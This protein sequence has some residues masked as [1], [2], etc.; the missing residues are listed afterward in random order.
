MVHGHW[1]CKGLE[2][3]AA[4]VVVVVAVVVRNGSKFSQCYV[5]WGGLPQAKVQDVSLILV[6]AVFPLDGEWRRERKK[7]KRRKK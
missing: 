1:R 3:E 5:A 7:K 2:P 6:G 4:A